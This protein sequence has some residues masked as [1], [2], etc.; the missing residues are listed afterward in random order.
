M[1]LKGSCHCQCVQFELESQTPY[2]QEKCYCSICRKTAGG[3]GYAIHL[4]GDYDTLKIKG[5]EYIRIYQ[6]KIQDP[7]TGEVITGQ[8]Q[9]TFC[10]NCGSAL[11]K[12]DPRWPNLVHPLAS[13]IDSDLPIT[14]EHSNILVSSAANWVP[15]PEP[16]DSER[17]FD[18]YPDQSIYEWH[19]SRK[20][21]L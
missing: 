3:G 2:P 14:H 15:I 18:Q 19:A 5:K 13:A 4:M 9:N 7:E 1:K 12:Y 17:V 21:L 10:K 6:A 8:G 20:K 16:S 11:W